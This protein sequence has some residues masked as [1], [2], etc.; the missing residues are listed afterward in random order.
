MSHKLTEE[1]R[2]CTLLT[3]NQPEYASLPPAQIVPALANQGLYN[4]S[5]EDCVYGTE[6]SFYRIFHAHSQVHRRGRARPPQEL[7]AVPCLWAPRTNQL[8]S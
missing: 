2:Q 1:E 4:S 3:C 6:S 8:W 5:G 7:R